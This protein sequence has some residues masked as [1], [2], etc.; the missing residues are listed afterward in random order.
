M[1]SRSSVLDGPEI[2]HGSP[3]LDPD[4]EG[5][6]PCGILSLMSDTGSR[7][8]SLR[9]ALRF[10]IALVVMVGCS[11]GQPTTSD[12]ALSGSDIAAATGVARR[13]DGG[14]GDGGGRGTVPANT[15]RWF[16]QGITDPAAENVEAFSFLLP[17]GWSYQG[18]VEW[19]PTFS[20]VAFLQTTL[21][22]PVTATTIDWLPIQNFI[23][24][25]PVGGL[26]APLGGN[27]QGQI[28]LP[29]ITDPATFVNQ[30]W[31]PNVLPQL[32]DA[33]LV[34]IQQVP[35]VAQE[36]LVG[37]GGPADVAAYRLRYEYQRDG[38]TWEED[39]HFALLFAGTP[40]LTTWYVN[41]AYTARAPKGQL[42]TNAGL[43]STIVASRISSPQWE[44]MYR[45]VRQLF[46]QGIR[47]QIDDTA[48]LGRTL[49]QNRA[50]SQAQQAQVVAER[51]ASQDLIA[52]LRGETLAGVQTYKDPVNGGFVQLPIGFD[53]YWVNEKGEYLTSAQAGFD[54]NTLNSGSWQRLQL[55]NR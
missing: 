48:A 42:D 10:G 35:S 52:D 51:Q 16:R 30:F 54:P 39:V 3:R 50:E 20:R 40:E 44:G 46:L 34:D 37:F 31:T 18:R 14:G 15:V 41:F 4:R 45:M 24:F 9:H 29:P 1:P 27:Y 38:Q 17:E 5:P 43:I 13:G 6:L 33:T 53:D 19:M 21:T 28:Y 2:Q 47:R 26:E 55:R 22:D 32:A 11:G 36:F 25:Q 7:R 23:Y 49:A 8:S 12:D